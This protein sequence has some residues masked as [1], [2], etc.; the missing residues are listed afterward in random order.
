[1]DRLRACGNGVVPLV[2]AKAF[3]CLARE[4]GLTESVGTG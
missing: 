1:V 4:L 3:V 2:A